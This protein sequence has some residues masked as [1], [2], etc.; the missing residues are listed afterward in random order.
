MVRLKVK[1][2]LNESIIVEIFQFQSG[3]VKRSKI[4]SVI[5]LFETFQFQSGAVKSN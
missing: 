5:Q 4:E 2:G 3:A 1:T